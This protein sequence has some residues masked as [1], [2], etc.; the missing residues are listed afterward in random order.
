M[1]GLWYIIRSCMAAVGVAL[2]YCA[3]S[4]SDYHTEIRQADPDSVGTMLVWG[5]VLMVPWM[6]HKLREYLKE[7]RG[8]R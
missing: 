4:T 1:I 2:M 3:V 7:W 6:L 8:W 5:I